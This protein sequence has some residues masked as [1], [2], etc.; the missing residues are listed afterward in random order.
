MGPRSLARRAAALAPPRAAAVTPPRTRLE[1]SLH[2]RHGR[3]PPLP[4]RVSAFPSSR[5]RQAA[6]QLRHRLVDARLRRRLVD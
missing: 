6:D 5:L 1:V 4:R 3:A 2:R